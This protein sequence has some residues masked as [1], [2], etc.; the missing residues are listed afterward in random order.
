MVGLSGLYAITNAIRLAA[1]DRRQLTAGEVHNIMNVGFDF[2]SGRMNPRQAFQGGCRVS[3]WRGMAQAV[4]EG[5]R[6][7]L[8]LHMGLDRIIVEDGRSRQAT[9]AAIEG[10]IAKWR[11]V[12]LLCRGGRY[13]VV[14]G[15][16]KSS[17]LLF[18]SGGSRWIAKR[19][20]GVPGDAGS[21]THMLYPSSFMA[22]SA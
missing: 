19:A 22:L 16:T 13:T 14:C 9:F 18:D 17:L 3:V 10:A 11:P 6:F 8:G 5:A 4:V 15:F 7:R 20:C 12:M 21:A 2:L 1:A